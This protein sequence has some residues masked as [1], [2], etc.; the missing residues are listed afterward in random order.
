MKGLIF[1]FLIFFSWTAKGQ[2][3]H[4]IIEDGKI[5]WQKVYDSQLS[6]EEIVKAMK[7]TGNFTDISLDG[8][9][10]TANV[11]EFVIDYEAVGA[12]LM[13]TSMYV[14]YYD[15]LGFVAI[16]IKEGKY[17]VTF[18]NIAMNLNLVMNGLEKHPEF[19]EF[20]LKNGTFRSGFLKDTY[21]F[22]YT[23]DKKFK[24][25]KKSGGDW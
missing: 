10:I 13:R 5:A 9:K 24:I 25:E 20:S 16:D 12:K 17:R 14:T 15:Y 3:H 8:D 6:A 22:E 21:L 18:K 4:F 23:F 19:S 11:N 2:E 7:E 1:V